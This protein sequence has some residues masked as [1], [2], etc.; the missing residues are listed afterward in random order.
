MKE[1]IKEIMQQNLEKLAFNLNDKVAR[2][3]WKYNVEKDIFINKINFKNECKVICDESN[4]PYKDAFIGQVLYTN[5][6]Y[7]ITTITLESRTGSSFDEVYRNK[8][9]K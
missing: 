1:K 6:D 2:A 3:T 5:D 8:G 7:T 9:T 4:N